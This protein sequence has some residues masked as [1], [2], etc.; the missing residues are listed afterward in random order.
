MNSEDGSIAAVRTFTLFKLP[1]PIMFAIAFALGA[2]VHHFVPLPAWPLGR[3]A[4]LA[5]AV[6]LASGMCMG[7]S[8][9]ISFLLNRTTLNPFAKPSTF[10]VRGPY[11]I[12][13]N[14]MYV[15]L[16]IVYLGGA[17]MLGSVWPLLTL[18]GPLA[19]LLRVVIPFEEA[20][21]LST[22]GDTYRDYCSS[23][24]RWL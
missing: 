14:P 22:F 17:L 12:S 6:I 19:V 24:R 21:M 5:G 3:P 9:A 16:V 11:R 7:A 13:R 18:F 15:T 2:T 23:V 10:V 1:P 8:L 4:Y 20:R